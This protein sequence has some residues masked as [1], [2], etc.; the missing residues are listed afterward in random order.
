MKA[1]ALAAVV[2][3]VIS[4]ALIATGALVGSAL[5]PAGIP[6]P[7]CVL[8][9]AVP[10]VDCSTPCPS[11]VPGLPCLLTPTSTDTPVNTLTP[12]ETAVGPVPTA[13]STL[14][15]TAVPPEGTETPTAVPPEGT[16][17]PTAVPPES[18][19]TPTATLPSPTASPTNTATPTATPVGLVGDVNCNGT[20][21]TIDAALVLQHDAGLVRSLACGRLGDI[22][23]DARMNSIDATFILQY[24]ARLIDH[25][26][27]VREFVGTL[28]IVRG[29]EAF[30]IALDTGPERLV[31]W[32]P[33]GF[34]AGQ[35]V[36]VIG[37]M[38]AF[39]SF[40]GITPLLHNIS[41]EALD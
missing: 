2:L 41:I 35:R 23:G 15:S 5:G 21:N 6:L 19:E 18:T 3:T 4:V 31:L 30:C 29:V 27:P 7:T 9:T 10:G 28:V 25:L 22:N 14:T 32:D 37:F 40:C 36:R 1:G 39:A 13:T 34:S 26:P 24:A 17:T 33:T 8:P 16:E 11:G 12:T 38:D 20:V